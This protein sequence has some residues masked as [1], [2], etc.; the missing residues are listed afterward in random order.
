MAFYNTQLIHTPQF[1]RTRH[2]NMSQ[3]QLCLLLVEGGKLHTPQFR[4]SISLVP[5]RGQEECPCTQ[6]LR[7]LL[8]I[9]TK[10]LETEAGGRFTCAINLKFRHKWGTIFV[11]FTPACSLRSGAEQSTCQWLQWGQHR[12]GSHVLCVS[13]LAV[14]MATVHWPKI[15]WYIWKKRLNH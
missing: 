2:L 4:V 5:Y 3:I 6:Q 15:S 14:M 1:H 11:L 13:R 10:L 12:P 8:T 9:E 7:L